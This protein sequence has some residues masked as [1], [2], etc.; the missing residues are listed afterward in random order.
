[1]ELDL[2][3]ADGKLDKGAYVFDVHANG[4]SMLARV[5]DTGLTTFS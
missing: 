1:M 4:Q 5:R 3:T 2:L